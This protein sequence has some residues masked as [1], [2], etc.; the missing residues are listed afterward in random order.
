MG[1]ERVIRARWLGSGGLYHEGRRGFNAVHVIRDWRV[2]TGA[3]TSHPG[4]RFEYRANLQKRLDSA[5]GLAYFSKTFGATS[6]MP[7]APF[8]C[9]TF[10]A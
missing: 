10:F 6:D 3:G 9:S 2:S 4:G 7:G 8:R 1:P 5:R